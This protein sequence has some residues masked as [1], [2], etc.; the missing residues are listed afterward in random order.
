MAEAKATV[1]H[2]QVETEVRMEAAIELRTELKRIAG[3]G[4]VPSFNDMIVRAAAFALRDHPKANGAYVGGA[5]ELH[6]RVNVGIA[7][8]VEDALLVPTI[9]DADKK[10]LGRSGAIP[11]ALPHGSG[12]AR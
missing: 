12:P 1:P 5:F 2:F 6:D 4:P 8:A 3:E 9:L 7:V 10:S 11:G